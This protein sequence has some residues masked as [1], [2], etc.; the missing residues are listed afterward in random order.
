MNHPHQPGHWRGKFRNAFRGVKVGVQGESSFKVHFFFAGAVLAAGVA[1]RIDDP[2]Q[3]CL[4]LLCIAVVLAAE[5]FNSALE[6]MAKAVS[7]Q[8]D[9]NVGAA[10]DISSAAVLVAAAG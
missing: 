10:L 8:P 5:L 2:R 3:W 1:L 4:L 9:P 6:R 7:D